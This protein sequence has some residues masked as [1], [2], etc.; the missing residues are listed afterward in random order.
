MANELV[1]LQR[2]VAKEKEMQRKEM[3]KRRLQKELFLLRNRKTIG[4]AKKIGSGI[5]SAFTKARSSAQ[6]IQK[7]NEQ[8][9]RGKKTKTP[10][11]NEP[12]QDWGF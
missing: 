7:K 3:E 2:Q 12:T 4:V 10:S 9:T 8:R 5:S 11:F 1:S 6:K